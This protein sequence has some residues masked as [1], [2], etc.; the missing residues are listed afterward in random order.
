[1]IKAVFF[2]IDGTLVS[3]ATHSIPQSTLDVVK[4]TRREGVKVF[5]ATGRPAVMIDNLGELEYDGIISSN[6]AVCTLSSGEVIHHEGITPEDVDRLIAYQKH[7]PMPIGF[8]TD[9]EFF[10]CDW[11]VGGNKAEEVWRLLNCPEPRQCDIEEAR[12]KSIVQLVP[13]F[14]AEDEPRIMN[15]VL[16]E[17]EANRWHRDFADCIAKGNNKATGIDH[18]C[19]YYGIS[20]NETAAFGDGGNDIPMLLH[21]GIGIAMGNADENVKRAA[22]RVADHVDRNGV[23]KALNEILDGK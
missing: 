18:V 10:A 14:S 13:F 19:R 1:M 22:D 23:S 7:S 6:G 3:F 12:G 2:D 15:E 11:Y 4:R 9:D 5:I 21:A 16:I 8:A 17:S 20:P